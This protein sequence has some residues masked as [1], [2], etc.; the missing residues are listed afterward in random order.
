MI[1]INNLNAFIS[2]KLFEQHLIQQLCADKLTGSVII[3][4]G[5]YHQFMING[6]HGKCTCN[7][8]RE[9]NKGAGQQQRNKWIFP[10]SL[11][12]PR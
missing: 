1:K 2:F 7:Q 6:Q 4:Q 3:K 8:R 5:M 11:L 9:A 10:Q 12:K